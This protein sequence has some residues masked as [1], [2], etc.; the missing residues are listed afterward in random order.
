MGIFGLWVFFV[1][2]G[3]RVILDFDFGFGVIEG[4][5]VY[6]YVYVVRGKMFVVW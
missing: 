1:D 4:L 5:D 6:Y 2:I 3:A